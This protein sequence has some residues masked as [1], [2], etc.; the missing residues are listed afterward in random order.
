M[1]DQ[2]K[3]HPVDV[4]AAPLPASS[5]S[6]PLV[7][8]DLQRSDKGDPV[9]QYPPY[10]R[11]LPLA[12]PLSPPKRRRSRKSCCCK[13]FC[14]TVLSLLLLIVLVVATLGILYVV[15]KPK[16]PKYSVDRLRVTAFDVDANLTAHATFAVTVTAR[17]PNKRVGI[18]YEE[19][20]R[21]NV[22]YSGFDLCSG[23][24]P[25]F[26]QGH[27]NTSVVTVELMGETKVGGDLMA[28]LQQQQQTGTVPLEFR[29]EVPVRVKFGALKLWKMTSKVR[30]DL[31]VDSLNANNQISIK[32]SNCKFKG[33]KL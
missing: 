9:E 20:S 8:H 28:A 25:V 18:Y 22:L 6:A 10:R 17:N 26:Y 4:E 12:P 2:Q 27:H 11:T 21:L 1:T 23:S 32:S 31:V 33:F 29:G 30:C 15:F 13:C 16:I 14:W 19:G 24:F 3:I 5:P 7:P